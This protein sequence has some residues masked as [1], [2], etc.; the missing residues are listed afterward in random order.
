MTRGTEQFFD[1]RVTAKTA[2]KT[3]MKSMLLGCTLLILAAFTACSS[4]DESLLDPANPVEITVWHYYTGVLQST[5]DMMVTEFNQTVGLERGVIIEAMGFGNMGGVES[6]LRST[7]AGEAGAFPMPN[8]FSAFP[9]TAYTPQRL[10]LLLNLDDYLTAAQLAEYFPPFIERGRMGAD[11]ELYIF[12]VAMSA[13]IM[14]INETDWIAFASATAFAF[15]DLA[16]MESLVNVAQAYYNWSGGRAFWGRDA[17]ANMFIIGSK[18]FGTEIFEIYE[19]GGEA[20]ARININE[21]VMR[22]FWDL[23]YTPFISGYFAAN[24][25]F[26]TDDVRVG[27]LIGFVGSTASAAFFPETMTVDGEIRYLRGR[28]LPPPTFEGA[29]NVIVKQGAGKSVLRSTDQKQYASVLFLRWLTEPAQNLR[30]SA[31]SGRIPVRLEVMDAAQIRE[32]AYAADLTISDITYQTLQVAIDAIMTSEMYSTCAFTG[33]VAARAV[34]TNN[35]RNKAT[36]DRQYVLEQIAAGA[37]RSE[38][39]AQFSSDERFYAW[40]NGLR[41]ALEAAVG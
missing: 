33:A 15:E 8:I 13:E 35:L 25:N 37:P 20:R 27:D 3:T 9:D 18:M 17:I 28:A 11:D 14:L 7:I 29:T 34:L 2:M 23:Y 21:E 24:A 30:F 12:P 5:F 32:A 22:R 16:T 38:V 39:I 40:M 41:E 26:R 19:R 4:E 1:I 6:N 31:A 10:G 36:A